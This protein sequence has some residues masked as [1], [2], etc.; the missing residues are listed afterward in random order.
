MQRRRLPVLA[1]GAAS[2]LLQVVMMNLKSNRGFAHYGWAQ[3]AIEIVAKHG[4]P[5]ERNVAL[6]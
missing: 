1:G 3:G 4:V 2:W 5:A 6:A